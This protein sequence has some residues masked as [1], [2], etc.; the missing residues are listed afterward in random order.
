ML[1]DQLRRA[2][3]I[4]GEVYWPHSNARAA[5]QA[6]EELGELIVAL[7]QHYKRDGRT[8]PLEVL[9]EYADVVICMGLVSQH[10]GFVEADLDAMVAK[11]ITK[12]TDRLQ[13]RMDAI[14]NG[15]VASGLP[16]I[17]GTQ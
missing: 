2:Y 13:P 12:M 6:V 15:R 17:P 3:K 5:D 7:Q 1:T 16:P 14:N 10:L 11:K 8:T 9:E 4:H